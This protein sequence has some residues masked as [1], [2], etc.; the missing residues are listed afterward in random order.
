MSPGK[1]YSRK[2]SG[3]SGIFSKTQIKKIF[4]FLCCRY[5]NTVFNI[6]SNLILHKIKPFIL[7]VI[8]K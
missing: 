8:N 1:S 5:L 2:A 3:C 7:L 6:L 4:C